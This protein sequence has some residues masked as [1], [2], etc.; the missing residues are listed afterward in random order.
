MNSC[1]VNNKKLIY[2]PLWG[3]VDITEFI[4]LI[5]TPQFQSLGFK[6][7]LGT[8]NFIFPAATHTRKQHSLG[9]LRR[10]Q[11]LCQRWLE[12]GFINK[13]EAK[14]IKA[15][16]LLHDIGHGPFSH[17][18]EEVTKEIW[19][20]DHDQNGAKIISTLKDPIEQVGIDFN[21]F[22]KFF[23]HT[24]PLYLAV[25]DKNLGS[26]KLD[27]LSRDAFYTLGEKP[28]VEYL[29]QHTYFL[30]GEVLID[31]KAIDS[32]KLL[33]DFY[34]RMF[35]MVYLRKNS[36]ISQRLLQRLTAKLLEQEAISETKLWSLTDFGLLGRLEGTKS[37][38]IKQEVKRF[39]NRDFPSTAIAFKID[40][41][42][43]VESGQHKAQ[44]IFGISRE[45]MLK[46]LNSKELS[47]PSS[48]RK[49]ET[50]LEKDLKMPENSIL[51]SP[52]NSM[53]RFTPKDVKVYS[54][55]GEIYN[56]SDYFESH[57]KAIE[58]EGDSYTVIRICTFKENRHA[59]L[60]SDKTIQIAKDAIM[61]IIK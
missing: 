10:T 46:L 57:F 21:E 43:G 51:I 5:D 47:T 37:T 25:H 8:T 28:G 32:A 20:R 40:Q 19:G 48:I 54:K 61:Q 11:D 30:D 22:Q 3:L 26:E 60:S 38:E 29:A 50:Q 7:Q 35:K 34:V 12:M 59:L 9:A 45:Q 49:I 23:D 16:A 2:D 13:K 55:R 24:N 27:Y 56:L 6:Y 31:E 1:P 36:T 42:L 39:L 14:M 4:S 33:Q 41:F 44:K 15:F 17:V 52:A 18:V 53:H 58:E